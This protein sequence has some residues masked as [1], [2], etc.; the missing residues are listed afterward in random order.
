MANK[1]YGNNYADMSEK[2]RNKYTKEEFKEARREERMAGEKLKREESYKVDNLADF[3]LAAGGA[4]SKKGTERLSAQDIKGLKKHGGFSKQQIIDYAESHDF[5]DGPGA[6]GGKAQKLLSRYKDKIANRPKPDEVDD[7]NTTPVEPVE[8]PTPTSTPAPAPTPGV[9]PGN[10]QTQEMESSTT[11]NGDNNTVTNNQTIDNSTTYEASDRTF[12]Y[13]G[14]GDQTKDTPV[15]AATMSGLYDVDD[16]PAAQ[17]SF[18]S[19]YTS[20][21]ADN[22]KRYAGQA[23]DTF[24]KYGG[25]DARSYTDESMENVINR[26]TQYSFDR[27]DRQTGHVFGDI[28]NDNY[29]TEDWKMPTPPKAIESNAKDIADDAKEDIEDL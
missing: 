9:T 13:Q 25:F 26:S 10:T 5:G 8:D 1:L 18:N 15:S 11:V 17:K 22:Q 21:N 20:M 12:N 4:G 7:N 16:S 2:Y 6:S 28:W 29:I 23:M 24:K 19:L 14:T 3:D 27:A